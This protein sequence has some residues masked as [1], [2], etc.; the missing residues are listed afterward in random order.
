MAEIVPATLMKARVDRVIKGSIDAKY[1]KILVTE[2]DCP[3]VGVGIGRR[4]ENRVADQSGAHELAAK[5]GRDLHRMRVSG[6]DR[7]LR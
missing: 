4:R 5:G 1:V 2:L 6:D 7:R 3:Q